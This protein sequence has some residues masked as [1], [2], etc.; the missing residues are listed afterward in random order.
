M[1]YKI[2]SI[3]PQF[4]CISQFLTLLTACL[5]CYVASEFLALLILTEASLSRVDY[6]LK[7]CLAVSGVNI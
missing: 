7:I 2:Y 6:S 4:L 3:I 1:S 5:K